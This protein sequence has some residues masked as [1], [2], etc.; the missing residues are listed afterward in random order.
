ML[1]N[2]EAAYPCVEE[3]SLELVLGD[4]V[5]GGGVQV[6]EVLQHAGQ[7]ELA[8]GLLRLQLLACLCISNAQIMRK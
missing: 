1:R 2:A 7:S 5:P 4:L 6:H 3:L 8:D